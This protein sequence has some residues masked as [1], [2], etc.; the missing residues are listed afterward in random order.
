MR[1][2]QQ[3]QQ[4]FS[5][6]LQHLEIPTA[7][8]KAGL[9]Y[10][11]ILFL[12][13]IGLSQYSDWIMEYDD[14]EG[15]ITVTMKVV[16]TA[17]NDDD[18]D[19]FKLWHSPSGGVGYQ[20]FQ[21][22]DNYSQASVT[23]WTTSY[24]GEFDDDAH[25]ASHPASVSYVLSGE[26]LIITFR[27][28][29][30]DDF[31]ATTTVRALGYWEGDGD[32]DVDINDNK[33]T[34]VQLGAGSPSQ[35]TATAGE[36]CSKVRL[37]WTNDNISCDA[38]K[39]STQIQRKLASGNN[40]INLPNQS[41]ST[42]FY[43]DSN[44]IIG[45]EYDYRIRHIF[46]PNP[47]RVDYSNWVTTNV[48][49]SSIGY[50][51]TP[52]S[53][54]ASTA[55]C[56]GT[57][58]LSWA[59][60]LGVENYEI[61]N[62]AYSLLTTLDGN[63]TNYTIENV[64][65][66]QN[67]TYR[68]RAKNECNRYSAYGSVTGSTIADPAP[69]TGLV[70]ALGTDGESVEVSWDLVPYASAYRIERTLLGGG[71][72]FFF[73]INPSNAGAAPPTEYVDTSILPCQTYEYRIRAVNECSPNG[74]VG[75]QVETI[76]LVPELNNTFNT[77]FLGASESLVGSK[78]FYP[79]RVELTWAVEN[80][81]NFI[82]GFKI[83]R[84]QLGDPN[85][86][87]VIATLNA[88]SNI[89]VDNL[90][91][92]G[93]LYEYF[94]TAEA[95]CESDVLYSN[96]SRTI[97]FRNPFG[98]VTG[99]VHY[100]GNFPVEGARITAE[101]S[102]NTGQS[103]EFDGNSLLQIAHQSSL[104]VKDS[105]LLE[106]WIQPDNYTNDFTVIRKS[107]A[108]D[109]SYSAAD[110][111]YLFEVQDA[112]GALALAFFDGSELPTG[113]FSHLAA[114][115]YQDTLR[116]FVNGALKASTAAAYINDIADS[117]TDVEI[118]IGFTGILDEVR[119]WNR[120]KTNEEIQLDHSRIMIGNEPGLK[121]YLRMD[122]GLPS[123]FSY[124]IS[125]GPNS[126]NGNHA[127]L[128]N[129]VAWSTTT[130]TNAQ[131]GVIA[132]TGQN[133]S[134]TMDIP[135]SG[136]GE[137]FTLTPAFL[138]HAPFIPPNEA[139]YI[140]DGSF[141]HNNVDFLD[142][143]SFSVS[144]T[145]FYAAPFNN[146]P[147]GGASFR[148]DGNIV[149]DP[150]G[151][152]VVTNNLGVYEI[153]VPIGD[154][155]IEVE[156]NGHVFSVGRFPETGNY[157]FQAPLADID[158][159]DSTL[160][161]VVGRVV[162]GLR[163]AQK[164]PGMGRS[165][166]N[167][168][169]AQ[170]VLA[171]QLGNG[172]A[173]ATIITDQTTGEYESYL[174]P[175]KYVPSVDILSN[176]AIDF[177]TLNLVDLSAPLPEQTIIDTLL[178]IN[179]LGGD[180]I[181][182][183]DTA[184][185]H[186]N[187]P[188]TYRVPAPTLIVKDDNG[189][190]DFV[191]DTTYAYINSVTG[192][193]TSVDLRSTPFNM[194]IFHQGDDK[195]FYNCKIVIFEEYTN[196]DG[197]VGQEV[198]DSVPTTDGILRIN[199]ELSHAPVF[200]V[201]L[202]KA[203]LSID[204][205]EAIRYKF[206]PGIP[207]FL[208]NLNNP[209]YSF[210][211]TFVLELETSSGQVIAW[212]PPGPQT[213][214]RGILLGGHSVSSGHLTSGP[215]IV[216][217]VLRDPPGSN[218]SATRESGTTT[219]ENRSWSW[220]LG[221]ALHV[222]N[223]IK[224]GTAFS[225]GLGVST[226]TT[227]VNNIS[228]GIETEISGGNSGTQAYSDVTTQSWT[229]NQGTDQV[230]A[231]S[232][233]F[234]AQAFNV[235]VGKASYLTLVPNTIC[236][237]VECIGMMGIGNGFNPAKTVSVA[238]VPGGYE[239]KVIYNQNQ[240]V[241]YL[242]PGLLEGRNG[243]LQS[244]PRYTSNLPTSDPNYGLNN[245][246]PVF[247]ASVSSADSTLTEATD[248]TGL[249]YTFISTGAFET[250]TVR[251]LN[252]QVRIWKDALKLNEWEKVNIGK[253]SVIDSLKTIELEKL[254]EEYSGVEAAYLAIGVT[255]GIVSTVTT[256]AANA[257]IP[258]PGTAIVGYAAFAT[259]SIT[260]I[261]TT[262]LYEE[263]QAYQI[264]K[265][266]LE[267]KFAALGTPV[268]RSF[269]GADGPYTNTIT[270]D[271]SVTRNHSYNV[272]MS[273]GLAFEVAADI[274][275]AGAGFTNGLKLNFSQERDWG[276]ETTNTESISYT[277]EDADQG[278]FYSVDV[279]PS[280]LGWG[281]VFKVRAGGQTSCPHELADSTNYYVNN[282]TPYELNAA[283]LQRQ[284]P[285]ISSAQTFITNVPT[286]EAAVFN[287][288]LGNESESGD[289]Q[290]YDVHI[291]SISN[292]DGAIVRIDGLATT[293]VS[294]P[295][296]AAVNKVLT[297]EKGP[298]PVYN[299]DSLLLV[300]YPPCQ[301][302]AGSTDNV[303]IG[304]SLYI[305]AHFLPSCTEV[306]LASPEDQWVLNNAFND[307]M[308][309]A[310]VDYNINFFDFEKM[311]FDYKP[312]NEPNWIGLQT[313]WRDTAGLN[314]P[315]LVEIPSGTPFTLYDWD[316]AQLV[317]GEYDLRVTTQCALV[318]NFSQTYSGV[319]DRI[320][321]HPFGN[322]TPADGIL[323]P[324]D[325]ISIKFNEPID[326]G[327]LTSMNFD[328][329]GVLNGT[330][331]NHYTS[332]YF[333]G[334]DDYVEVTGGA[335]L[336]NRDFTIEFAVRRNTTGEEAIMSQ[337][338][339]PSEHLFIGFNANN[340]L[341]FRIGAEEAI[342]TT[343]FADNDWHNFAISYNYDNETVEM[344]LAGGN[345]TPQIINTGSTTIY[346]DY[347][348]AG[349]LFIGKNSSNNGNFFNGNLHD[350]RVWSESR[351]LSDF[352]TN[353]NRLLGNE[354]GLLYNWRMDEA[355]GDLLVDHVRRRD[356]TNQG[357]SWQIDPSGFAA[358][359]DGADDYLDVFTGDVNITEEMDFT[360][361]F[362]FNS[363]QAGAA[364]LFSN[365]TGDGLEVDSL[366]SW[367]INK[368]ALGQ[369][370]V[371]HYGL[372]FIAVTD[373]YFDGEWHHF[374][375]VLQ[376]SG[377]LSAYIDGNFQNSTQALPYQELGGSNMYLGARAYQ[378]GVNPF[379]VSNYF[380]GELDEFRFWNTARK[381]E[382]IKRD[383][384]NRMKADELGLEIYLPFEDYQLDPTGIPILTASFNEQIDP[385]IHIVTNP[386]GIQNVGQTPTIKIQRPVG[387]IAFTYSVNGDEIIFTPTTSQELIEN[388][389]LD[390]TVD[391]VKDLQGNVM[392]SPKTWIA[393]INKNQVLWQDESLQFDME[394]GETLTFNSGIINEGGAAKAF[395]ILNIPDWLTVSPSS[396]TIAPNSSISVDFEVDPLVSIGDYVE[397]LQL[398]TDFNYPE[399]LT[400]NLKVRSEEPAWSIDPIDFQYSMGI[401]GLLEIQN[402]VSSDTEDKLAAFVD[403]E[404]RGTQ[405]LQYIPQADAYLVFMD[406]YG[407]EASGES[408]SFQI[409]DASAG[410]VYSEIEPTLMPFV[411]DT[412]IGSTDIPEIF[413]T[414]YEI[415]HSIPVY[416]GWN[417]ISDFLYN[418]DSTN[419]DLT[420]ESLSPTTGD[421]LK[422]QY[423]YSDFSLA[424][425]WTGALNEAGIRPEQLYKLK[426]SAD[427]LLVLKGNV[428]NPT[429]RTI[430]LVDN[431]NWIGFISV[432]NQPLEQALGNLNAIEG[433]LIKGQAEFAV[434][435]DSWGWI[436]SLE[437]MIPGRGYMYNSIGN[438]S[439][440]YPIAGYFNKLTTET[441][442]PDNGFWTVE[443][444]EYTSNMTAI[445]SVNS[446]CE[447]DLP[448]GEFSIGLFDEFGRIRSLADIN[449]FEG[450]VASFLTIAGSTGE[451]LTPRILN[452][453]TG[454]EF[455]INS[456][457]EYASDAHIGSL[458]DPYKI[459]ISGAACQLLEGPMPEGQTF[460]VYPSL[461]ENEITVHY[462]SPAVDEQASIR[463]FNSIGQLVFS[464]ELKVEKGD[465]KLQLDFSKEKLSPGVYLLE[466]NAND[467]KG[468]VKVMKGL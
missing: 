205:L 462:M 122:E 290:I 25:Y 131:L 151:Q 235:E 398:M 31:G 420:L 301:Y 198:R 160:I 18:M 404:L 382:Q 227:F 165:K 436:G 348:G 117:P 34:S 411:S 267:D 45:S 133:G 22:D 201:D 159:T 176:P 76:Q 265:Q 418:V 368:D 264:E 449:D 98:T 61:Y 204:T 262:E 73:D 400:I 6:G 75:G 163:E 83:Y 303:D 440:V 115:F 116:L 300:I 187:L 86:S 285:S 47:Y 359:F 56:D 425:G 137:V 246:D 380:D 342:S 248:T 8:V 468:T 33:T 310:I 444:G 146:C 365:G 329:R 374:A 321:P 184:M 350:I 44:I 112:S 280:M 135:Y 190:D 435:D 430:S 414:N 304:D 292:P 345:T 180:S 77:A 168:G 270:H 454:E 4:R 294:I 80:N 107:N 282:G 324:N 200:N 216:D 36:Y 183:I 367:N 349:K 219:T 269:N 442:D 233:R 123:N 37:A 238:V 372:D 450:N 126:Y 406:V 199:N 419:L 375:I 88:G 407:N 331:T 351:S 166:N 154:H 356:G 127:R 92:A 148:I 424:N 254:D 147:V 317:D 193:T 91:D 249:S 14:C 399:R 409:W 231:G 323:D 58:D 27:N 124:D 110:D 43:D 377:N 42:S 437:T 104:N 253:E 465:N 99:N 434:Y 132:Y 167:I 431:W 109:L 289:P 413:K 381:V 461:F 296:G 391:G 139:L 156:K 145:V 41:I 278:D 212:D 277:L 306:A 432:R 460:A 95:P 393:Y 347:K 403:G 50:P 52:N 89:Y 66:N 373:D 223:K 217:Y 23:G 71:G 46:R 121:A 388:V 286:A 125:K 467:E 174:P 142:E 299:Y 466:L 129:D 455:G 96:V 128:V 247:G 371:K 427:D 84:R 423:E 376:R 252:D 256:L 263:Y 293:S 446:L 416:Q 35:L 320:N 170:V 336:Q 319:M 226:E 313:F 443:Y 358:S 273:A 196:L 39:T 335:A 379:S 70:L 62:A 330:P 24:V 79:N 441:E 314:D 26:N 370:H 192:D 158:F 361:E 308:P 28:A 287:L 309:V 173:T 405:Y 63:I 60:G 12:P 211:K 401:I 243:I 224:L 384:Q 322:P 229:T 108:Y 316:A 415:A 150:S 202:S 279:Y 81:T 65:A 355:E 354:L 250:D 334:L 175:L 353:L 325:E 114:Q 222:E 346:T 53:L 338:T 130:P 288:T 357:A 19:W 459:N 189:V 366:T 103:L 118:G 386:N 464:T 327:S 394:S 106:T 259:T 113:D 307:T 389:T 378:L 439:F 102:S 55:N 49:G 213:V 463:L 448:A 318:D 251:W 260:G 220:N 171:S 10:L 276:H 428:I 284:K 275:G 333:D 7:F 395:E 59:F 396:G 272:N 82:N 268:N 397:D 209:E 241:N 69:P 177:G 120:G 298:G 236:A 54:V 30:D 144:G 15:T 297:V 185:F 157:N 203:G 207:S 13:F 214:F 383:K 169:Q 387:G 2:S 402:V 143:S 134:Y 140:G 417:W 17:G 138:S 181:V 232:D 215:Q 194:P 5:S 57:I 433:D 456:S 149:T 362:W 352:S 457:I 206:K 218:S 161:K 305:S 337:G 72:S 119:I 32:P 340:Q 210:T 315:T 3:Q 410:I 295:G 141:I 445:I 1:N 234:I 48:A 152:P 392:A 93:V 426:V 408:L 281:P 422:G 40:W 453:E 341:L 195:F 364:T 136:I 105:L 369:I 90:V 385:V 390:I 186:L 85:D 344:F 74:I 9:T 87:T 208:E 221:G 258:G 452:M 225:T 244:D 261:A 271:K 266:R 228:T 20:F 283:T 172:C 111:E 257:L 51:D 242:I 94:I 67:L 339:D 255:G 11:L 162:G 29:P 412:L 153:R 291:S 100:L 312:S 429:E 311:R 274:G 239:T 68:I 188:Y 245:D 178:A 360:L 97:G 328:I 179:Y 16:E 302:E 230:G 343:T 21:Y 438:K 191:G 332:L 78:G 237:D 447:N 240:I 458:D 421:E 451:V 164:V 363:T 101:S 197:G 155:W 38:S 64:P 182:S 326:L